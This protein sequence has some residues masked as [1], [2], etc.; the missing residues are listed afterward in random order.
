VKPNA[1]AVLEILRGPEKIDLLYSD[2]VMPGGM[3]GTELAKEA[4]RLRPHLK[5][6]LT[7]G[8]TELPVEALDGL[9]REVRILNKPFRRHDL[10]STLRSVLKA[11]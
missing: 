5:I 10:A 4:A 8:Y 2:D 11:G 1:P 7:S 6:L 3:F 9:G